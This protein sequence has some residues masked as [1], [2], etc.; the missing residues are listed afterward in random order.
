MPSGINAA[1]EEFE[2]KLHVHA[3]EHLSDLQGVEV[4]Q[5]DI[6]VIGSGDTLEKATSDHDKNF[7]KL[8][9]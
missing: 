7:L 6:L 5:D 3:I 9:K 4:L 2:C 1:S 8:L